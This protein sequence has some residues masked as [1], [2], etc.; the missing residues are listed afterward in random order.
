MKRKRRAMQVD[1]ANVRPL[2]LDEVSELRDWL[3]GMADE[4]GVQMLSDASLEDDE[5]LAEGP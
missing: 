2:T 3:Y 5:V 4:F 1:V